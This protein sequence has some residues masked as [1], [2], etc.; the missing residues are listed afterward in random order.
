M[1]MVIILNL[2]LQEEFIPFSNINEA[3]KSEFNLWLNNNI[4]Y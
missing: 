4:H 2:H 1:I 3:H